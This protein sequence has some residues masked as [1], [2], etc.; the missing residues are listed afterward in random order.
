MDKRKNSVRDDSNTPVVAPLEAASG[1][2][3]WAWVTVNFGPSGAP[4]VAQL[5]APT[6]ASRET[7]PVQQAV[8]PTI[9]GGR[10]R[11][12]VTDYTV[13][14]ALDPDVVWMRWPFRAIPILSG[15]NPTSTSSA[16]AHLLWL[17]DTSNG[18]AGKSNISS[19]TS[20]FGT[21]VNFEI[22]RYGAGPTG[23]LWDG[24]TSAVY[25]GLT[26]RRAEVF[27]VPGWGRRRE[28]GREKGQNI[29]G[30]RRSRRVRIVPAKV[31]PNCPVP[32]STGCPTPL[33]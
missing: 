5:G 29:R 11:S 23:L 13:N 33:T 27:I 22:I 9:W 21:T 16:P 3:G 24:G 17:S 8:A 6:K 10:K 30:A 12:P 4:I 2:G 28:G 26:S 25:S 31:K 20:E 14:A 19:Q 1:A 15:L 32:Q 18:T 7:R